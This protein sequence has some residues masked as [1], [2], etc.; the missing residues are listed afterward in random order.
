MHVGV[1]ESRSY[2]FAFCVVNIRGTVGGNGFVDG[3]D[4]SVLD[5]NVHRTMQS[6]AGIDYR[7]ALDKQI[8]SLAPARLL[9]SLAVSGWRLPAAGLSDQCARGRQCCSAGNQILRKF[10]PS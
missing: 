1:N 10:P 7:P 3:R 4:L 2:N 9:G 8:E 5:G 6:L